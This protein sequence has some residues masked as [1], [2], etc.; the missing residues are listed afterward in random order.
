MILRTFYLALLLLSSSATVAQQSTVASDSVMARPVCVQDTASGVLIRSDT[1]LR[2]LPMD[3]VLLRSG[4][5]V[6][7]TEVKPMIVGFT[8]PAGG[9][10]ADSTCV[11]V[12]LQPKYVRVFGQCYTRFGRPRT[13]DPALLTPVGLL[14]GT[15]V[16]FERG[17]N[18]SGPYSPIFYVLRE[19]DCQFQPYSVPIT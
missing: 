17:A 2:R 9:F 5:R 7:L 16:F 1:V 11:R 19:E 10:D 6:L 18:L 4:E 8:A 13:I 3:S 15:T 12:H 14:H